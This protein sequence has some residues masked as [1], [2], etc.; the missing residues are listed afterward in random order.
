MSTAI[1]EGKQRGNMNPAPATPKPNMAPK[2][3][4]G[5]NIPLDVKTEIE[6][7][8]RLVQTIHDRLHALSRT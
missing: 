4:G 7:L 8:R 6:N 5:G 3:Q 2:A 1:R